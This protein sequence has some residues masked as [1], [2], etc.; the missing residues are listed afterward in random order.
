MITWLYGKQGRL[1]SPLIW[2]RVKYLTT[3]GWIAPKINCIR[4]GDPQNFTL[5]PPLELVNSN[6][7]GE[8]GKDDNMLMLAF[9]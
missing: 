4:F 3:I 9:S 1:V 7:D 8:H 5:A 2:S 6:Y